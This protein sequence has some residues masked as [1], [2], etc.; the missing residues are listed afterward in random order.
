M[1]PFYSI[2]VDP[3]NKTIR[4]RADQMITATLLGFSAPKVRFFGKYASAS[5][6]EQA[7]MRTE[8]DGSAYQFLIAG[9]P[10][11]LEYY[12]EAGGMRSP[13]YKLNVVDLPSVKKLRVTYHFPAWTG[14]KDAVED[15]GGDLRAVEGTTAEVEVQTDRPLATGA[16]L[17]DDGS[18]V[19]LRAGGEWRGRGQRSH[20]EGRHLSHRRRRK[21]RGC[22]AERRLLHRSPEGPAAR[23][24]RSAARAAIIR[25]SPIEEVTVGVDAKDDFGLKEVSLHYSVNGGPEKAVPMLHAAGA[26]TSSDSAVLSLEDFKVQPGDIVSLYATAKDARKTV[27]TD[28]FFIEAQPFERNYTQSQQAGGGGGGGDDA[29]QQDQISQRQKEIIT[30]TWNQIKGRG[31]TRHRRGKRRVPGLRPV[32]AAR[33]GQIAGRSHEGPPVGRR[34]RFLQELRGRHGTGRRRPWV[35]PATS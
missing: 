13:S 28:I 14:M 3:G 2:K 7:D 15:P 6:W 31:A 26:K 10:E 30:A 32:Q 27:S 18:K 19:P 12:V 11:S 8:P 9:V 34:R 22:A 29:G 24:S 17:L 21:R 25:A 4:K 16:I 5:K 1:K 35:P 20:P 23:R 33:P